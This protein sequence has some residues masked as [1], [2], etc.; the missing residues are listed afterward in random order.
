MRSADLPYR[1][2]GI[3]VSRPTGCRPLQ[4]VVDVDVVA[5]VVVGVARGRDRRDQLKAVQPSG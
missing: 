1:N 5:V 3:Q 4:V 2:A